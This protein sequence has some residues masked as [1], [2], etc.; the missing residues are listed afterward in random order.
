MANKGLGWD[1]LLKMQI[2]LV[3]SGILGVS[4]G[5]FCRTYG[6]FKSLRISFSLSDLSELYGLEVEHFRLVHGF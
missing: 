1:S 6:D 4:M 5:F 3:V 2:I